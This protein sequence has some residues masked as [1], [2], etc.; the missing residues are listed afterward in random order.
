M[1][2][3]TPPTRSM[4]IRQLLVTGSMQLAIWGPIVIG[5]FNQLSMAF[6]GTESIYVFLEPPKDGRLYPFMSLEVS[7]WFVFVFITLI[8]MVGT[9]VSQQRVINRMIYP[10]WLFLCFLLISV[11]PVF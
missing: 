5:I 1:T 9:Y 3:N 2:S 8:S 6:L 10:L 11:K 7:W 4:D